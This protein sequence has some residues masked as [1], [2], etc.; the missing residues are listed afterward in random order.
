MATL[1]KQDAA[2]TYLMAVVM[3]F[4]QDGGLHALGQ[5]TGEALKH[6]L[7]V[8]DL[9]E[10]EFEDRLHEVLEDASRVFPSFIKAKEERKR[11]SRRS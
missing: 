10:T 11:A 4:L 5:R 8:R 6:L 2:Q 9:D 1:T 3:S 7:T